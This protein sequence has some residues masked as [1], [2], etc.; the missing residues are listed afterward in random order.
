MRSDAT[1]NGLESKHVHR[2]NRGDPTK[3]FVNTDQVRM[4]TSHNERQPAGRSAT[5]GNFQPLFSK[6]MG[7]RS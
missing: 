1:R 5:G 6:V 2:R 7:I 4:S 3:F